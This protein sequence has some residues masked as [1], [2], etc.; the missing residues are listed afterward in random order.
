MKISSCTQLLATFIIFVCICQCQLSFLFGSWQF[1][2]AAVEGQQQQPP[3]LQQPRLADVQQ[4]QGAAPQQQPQAGQNHPG[5]QPQVQ[6]NIRNRTQL[7]REVLEQQLLV[8][9]EV[10]P[11]IQNLSN[12]INE[13]RQELNH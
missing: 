10:R 1:R 2:P 6:Q 4:Q 9:Q 5:V 13:L 12:L 11:V 7:E 8:L 3:N